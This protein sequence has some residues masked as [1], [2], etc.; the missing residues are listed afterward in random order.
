MSKFETIKDFLDATQKE[1]DNAIT[2]I[3]GQIASEIEDGE[4]SFYDISEAIWVEI[5]SSKFK[6]SKFLKNQKFIKIIN[7]GLNQLGEFKRLVLTDDSKVI[8]SA[9]IKTLGDLGVVADMVREDPTFER[10]RKMSPN[11]VSTYF[12]FYCRALGRSKVEQKA[13]SFNLR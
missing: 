1:R 12:Y 2:Q 4:F 6:E 7:P 3:R 5:K 9:R 10:I 13:T 11:D 8:P